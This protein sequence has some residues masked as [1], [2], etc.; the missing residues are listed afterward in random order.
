[1]I[2][3]NITVPVR[4]GSG[5]DTILAAQLRSGAESSFDLAYGD[6]WLYYPRVRVVSCVVRSDR[7]IYGLRVVP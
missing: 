6:E 1:M 7:V 4:P 2:E 3:P 5:A